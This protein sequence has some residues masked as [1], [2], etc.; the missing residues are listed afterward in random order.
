MGTE[1]TARADTRKQFT[2]AGFAVS[3]S[4]ARPGTMVVRKHNCLQSLERNRAGDWAPVGPPRFIVCG[5]SCEL[6][7]RGYQKFWHHHGKRFPIR[8]SD[9]ETLHR[10]DEEVRYV[11]A[12]RTL[13]HESLGS[14]CARTAYDRLTGRPDK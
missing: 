2:D 1:P 6:E 8:K 9:L 4:G 14:T 3:E 13:Y 5:L 7:D 12:L 10:F 11:L